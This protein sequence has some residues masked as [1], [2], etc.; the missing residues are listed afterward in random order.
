MAVNNEDK[1]KNANNEQKHSKR[2]LTI[3]SKRR[4][5]TCV[6]PNKMPK[7]QKGSKEEIGRAHV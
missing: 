4:K 5:A 2:K 7:P 1:Q 6:M 3:M